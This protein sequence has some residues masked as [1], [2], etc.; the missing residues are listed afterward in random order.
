MLRVRDAS[1]S[2]KTQRQLN[3]YQDNIDAIADYAERV[4]VA[5]RE[6]ANKN[7]QENA[8]FREVREVLRSLCTGTLR[9]MYCEDS[10]PNQVE[11]I[12][13]KSLYP[14]M[15]FVWENYLYACSPCNLGKLNKFH[16]YSR[17]TGQ[18]VNVARSS[19]APV[20]PPEVGNP[21]LINPRL[22]DPLE[23]LELD[24]RDT[25]DFRPAEN[26]NAVQQ[27]R[28]EYTI[29]VLG[30]NSREHLRTSRAHA[31][32]L[33]RLILESYVQNKQAGKDVEELARFQRSIRRNNHATVWAEMKRQRALIPD[34]QALFV[35]APEALNW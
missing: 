10:Q 19:K 33:Y 2:E 25:F 14:E 34:L 3:E 28:A 24:I 7:R 18:K 1:L 5:D 16:V 29:D 13:P 31:Y 27:E 15:V 32:D 11:H 30:L 35:E 20:I 4:G 23:F 22:E 9:C 17:Q 8:A 6:F 26:L 21:L 12:K